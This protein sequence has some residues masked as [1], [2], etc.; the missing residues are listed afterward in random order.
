MKN[1]SYIGIASK[2]GSTV[3]G[4]NIFMKNVKL[5]FVSFNKKFEYESALMYLNDININK[6]YEKWV[7]D[8]NS[9][10]YFVICIN[11]IIHIL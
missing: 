4:S 7:T 9:K 5:P 2:D 11:C 1:N 3:T 6:F 8:S 10:I